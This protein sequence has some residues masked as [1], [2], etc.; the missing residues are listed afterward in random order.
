MSIHTK[1]QNK[2]HVIEAVC[3]AKFKFP[4]LQGLHISKKWDFTKLNA[5]GFEDM[6]VEKQLFHHGCGVKYIPNHGLD[7]W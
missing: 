4:V 2:E 1:L 5:S 3:R 7:K 6:V